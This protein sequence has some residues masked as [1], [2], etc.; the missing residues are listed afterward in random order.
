MMNEA[1]KTIV[2][3]FENK[4]KGFTFTQEEA[5]AIKEYIQRS[6]HSGMVRPENSPEAKMMLDSL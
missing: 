5:D 1:S 6:V 2:F 4:L 3:F